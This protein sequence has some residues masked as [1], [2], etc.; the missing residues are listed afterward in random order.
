MG[1]RKHLL[2]KLLAVFLGDN[3]EPPVETHFS[4]LDAQG[5]FGHRS[6]ALGRFT[7]RLQLTALS[8][9]R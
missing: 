5:G 1:A 8:M 4:Q 7:V 6:G 9:I 3:F 2:G